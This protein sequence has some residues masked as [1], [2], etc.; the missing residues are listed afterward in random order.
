MED[1]LIRTL[2]LLSQ[3]A[4]TAAD[5]WTADSDA[6]VAAQ[7]AVLRSEA[8]RLAEQNDWVDAIEFG[9]RFPCVEALATI[10]A[11][12]D[13]WD[14]GARSWVPDER[15][16]GSPVQRALKRLAAWAIGLRMGGELRL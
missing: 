9:V 16:S 11:L 12:D 7:Y 8:W 14:L 10:E 1:V 13:Q 15:E 5:G 4:E 6:D 2:K 3:R